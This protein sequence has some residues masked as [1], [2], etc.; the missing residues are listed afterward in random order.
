MR[1]GRGL[2]SFAW[3]MK[4]GSLRGFKI[5]KVACVWLLGEVKF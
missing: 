5:A 1:F 3:F 4:L 2:L